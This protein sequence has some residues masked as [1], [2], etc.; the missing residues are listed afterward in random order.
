[1]QFCG[2]DVWCMSDPTVANLNPT[3]TQAATANP[4]SPPPLDSR[5]AKPIL[6]VRDLHV[7]FRSDDRTTV[8]VHSLDFDLYPG[9][10]LGIV[11][12]SGSG[13]TVTSLAILGLLSETTTTISGQSLLRQSP[14]SDDTVDLLQL[15]SRQMRT[16]RGDRIAMVFQEPSSALNPVYTCGFQVMETILANENVSRAEARQR[17]LDLFRE[18][19]LP[20]PERMLDRYPHQLSGGQMQRVTI[21]IALSCNP[22]ILIADEPTT[23]LDVTVQAEI[24]RLM[25]D[26]QQRR[27]MAILFIT[28][29]LGVIAEIADRVVVMY[30]GQRVEM[31]TV[32]DIFER[33]QSPYTK[34]LLTCRPPLNRRMKVLPTTADFMQVSTNDDGTLDIQEKRAGSVRQALL[35]AEMTAAETEARLVQLQG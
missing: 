24:L 32:S 16:Y 13:K 17:T 27:N 18:V 30:R 11:G 15:S 4:V 28:H 10:T 31:G 33:P 19:Q 8:A 7:E 6:S 20:D 12:E 14:D 23:A 35:D 25:Q 5:S 3:P 9:Q 22:Q 34:G 1:M 21:A 2:G 29:D 26:L